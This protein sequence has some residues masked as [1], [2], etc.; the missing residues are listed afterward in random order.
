MRHRKQ[1]KKFGRQWDQ[2][3]ALFK[4]MAK[5]LITYGRL[6]TTVTKAKELSRIAD[7]LVA[8]ALRNDL[9]ARRQAYKFIGNHE[10]VK[11]LF[12]EIGPLFAGVNGGYTRVVK[13][14]LP[15]AGDCAPMAVIEFSRT[16]EAAAEEKPKKA[17]KTAKAAPA[18]DK[19][20]KAKAE[21]PAAEA[22]AEAP[23]EEA[24]ASEAP[25]DDA[26]SAEAPAEE[27]AAPEAPAEDGPAPEGED[28]AEKK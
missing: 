18:G 15:R 21:A 14:G 27:A 26:A 9:H 25:A 16:A 2:R 10:L 23:A 7:G 24:P 8:L 12:D 28:A 4:N 22:S 13:L 6:R 3:K 11:K 5:S 20:K 19:P 17:A 1:G